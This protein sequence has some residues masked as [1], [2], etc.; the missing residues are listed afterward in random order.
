[1]LDNLHPKPTKA[2][3]L[4]AFFASV[5]GKR[6]WIESSRT[7]DLPYYVLAI[8]WR[9]CYHLLDYRYS[10]PDLYQRMYSGEIGI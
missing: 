7:E 5:F 4:S 10:K 8:K 2:S 6:V 1:M 9:G 3:L